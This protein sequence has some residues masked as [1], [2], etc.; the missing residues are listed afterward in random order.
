[1]GNELRALTEAALK[2]QKTGKN[3]SFHGSLP[4]PS[5]DT[6]G[7]KLISLCSGPSPEASALVLKVAA[8]MS[9]VCPLTALDPAFA[10]LAFKASV[11]E[12]LEGRITT[13]RYLKFFSLWFSSAH[14]NPFTTFF[15]A[16]N[17]FTF[18]S[19][20]GHTSPFPAFLGSLD[21]FTFSS[22]SGH[23]DWFP[24]FNVVF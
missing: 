9:R 19:F 3:E 11:T 16:L 20:L 7:F 4:G 10:C 2:M 8:L 14:A 13:F 22:Y 5:Q 6:I 18:R 1:M 24:V 17:P 23:V 21:P 12:A 15:G